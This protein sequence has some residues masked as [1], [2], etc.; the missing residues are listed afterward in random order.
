M[1]RARDLATVTSDYAES[2]EG[3]VA[4]AEMAAVETLV[5]E[6]RRIEAGEAVD[7]AQ[8]DLLR[9]LH[10]EDAI[11]LAPIE[12]AVP[13]IE[14]FDG[15]T[16]LDDLVAEALDARPE[17]MQ[18]DALVEA[19]E[20]EVKA[21]RYGLFVPR[22]SLNYSY[23]DFGGA[24]GASV[25]GLDPREDVS[26]MLY[27]QFDQLGFGSRSRLDQKRS[28]LR[29]TQLEQ[30]RTRDRIVAEVRDAFAQIRSL[31]Q[32][33]ALSQ[34]ASERAE[35]AYALNRERIFENEGLPLEAVRA[36][37]ALADVQLVNL[38]QTVRYSLAQM[39]L[40]TAVGNPL[41]GI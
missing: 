22:F 18:Y 1:Q 9:L 36:M 41:E 14:I 25:P 29:Q 6:Q 19:A 35:R 26:V 11:E 30:S 21:E 16:D 39:R 20:A 5:W 3:L 8:L 40:H 32:R 37:Q 24:P 2:G 23:G 7:R 28:E 10:I 17:T 34:T 31:K 38:D 13:V 15:G 4:D 27:W 12:T 33:M